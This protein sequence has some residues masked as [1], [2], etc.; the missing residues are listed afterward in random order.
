MKYLKYIFIFGLL[1]S[2]ENR[3]IEVTNEYILNEYWDDY[4]NAIEI[5]KM[6][7]ID[8]SLN[9]FSKDFRIES[10]HWNIANKLQIDS[11]FNCY[12]SGLNFMKNKPK[13]KGKIY[14]NKENDLTWIVNGE[15][16]QIIGNLKNNTWYKFSRL[17]N[18]TFHQYIFVDSIGK[19]HKFSVN[20]D[21]Y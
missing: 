2:C 21:N 3:K 12:Y 6:K 5:Q 11:T 10:N 15:K 20:L 16:K 13:L 17:K 9:I 1:I 18:G 7:V 19:T 4:N 8:S 14:F